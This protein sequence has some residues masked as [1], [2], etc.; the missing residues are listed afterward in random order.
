MK[1]FW[2]GIGNI[3]FLTLNI[4]DLH[5]LQYILPCCLF[6]HHTTFTTKR[7]DCNTV[8]EIEQELRSRTS[9]NNAC[10][11]ENSA[12]T[13]KKGGGGE[14]LSDWAVEKGALF[15]EDRPEKFYR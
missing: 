9:S 2:Q 11:M 6:N 10:M 5:N 3:C 1:A 15:A 7:Q 4:N 12:Q 14:V 8:D 13:M